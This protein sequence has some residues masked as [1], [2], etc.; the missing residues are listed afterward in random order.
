M[1]PRNAYSVFSQPPTQPAPNQPRRPQPFSPSSPKGPPKGS[2]MKSPS[3]GANRYTP[4]TNHNT[5]S[6]FNRDDPQGRPAAE[7]AF[8]TWNQMKPG[9]S[10]GQ[11]F[12][13]AGADN[14]RGRPA[15]SN[16]FTSK[17]GEDGYRDT[18]KAKP[19]WDNYAERKVPPPGMTRSNTTR[20]PRRNGFDPGTPGGDE[21]AA[22]NTSAYF[23]TSRGDRPHVANPQ[24]YPPPPPGPPPGHQSNVRKPEPLKP[25]PIR[26][27]KS[28]DPLRTFKS[29]QSEDPHSSRLSTPY[30]TS[31]GEKTFFSS[32]GLYRTA[33]TGSNLHAGGQDLNS[34]K[35]ESRSPTAAE[36]H[37]SASPRMRS[38][39]PH[40]SS[41]SSSTSSDEK[42]D[43]MRTRV[44]LKPRGYG[45][46]RNNDGSRSHDERPPQP[47]VTIED[48]DGTTTEFGMPKQRS[49]WSS[50]QSHGAQSQARQF[51]ADQAGPRRTST[52]DIPEGVQPRTKRDSDR[53]PHSPLHT[54]APWNN[55]DVSEPLEK[56][57][58]WQERFG[59]Q[60]D[61]TNRR[62]FD[63][64][65]VGGPKDTRP[66][67]DPSF[68]SRLPSA[69]INCNTPYWAI[70]SSVMPRKQPE[71]ACTEESRNSDKVTYFTPIRT[72][73]GNIYSFTL[74]NES[75]ESSSS[76][77]SQAAEKTTPFSRAEWEKTFSGDANDYL[78]PQNNGSMSGG[79]SSP[80]KGRPAT[81]HVPPKTASKEA[82][83]TKPPNQPPP[84]GPV[85]AP[86]PS[87]AKFSQ[88]Q[89]GEHFKEPSWAYPQ[90]PLSPRAGNSK[91]SKTP[92]KMSTTGKRPVPPSRPVNTPGKV[93]GTGKPG[94]QATVTTVI[95][96]D[97]SS[98]TSSSAMD[99][100]PKHTPPGSSQLGSNHDPIANIIRSAVPGSRSGSKAPSKKSSQSDF[101]SDLNLDDLKHAV[102]FGPNNSGLGDLGDL[103]ATLPFESAPSS[104]GPGGSTTPKDLALPQPPK[105]PH[106]PSTHKLTKESFEY[107]MVWVRK[108]LAEWYIFN[109]TMLAHFN[110]RQS[111]NEVE[112]PHN[113]LESKGE[114]GYLKYMAGV[115]QDFRVR[116]HW[117]V[118]WEK[119]KAAM[120]T[121]GD[122]RRVAARSKF[123]T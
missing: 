112:L 72:N 74:P 81:A 25:D 75:S 105:A 23:N 83:S 123:M 26:G 89:W 29:L 85:P 117:N 15:R 82:V 12:A 27:F 110:A 96:S 113:W 50:E 98:S 41:P 40:Y 90:T 46:A 11:G 22:R 21:P 44:K 18:A 79:R 116:E 62:H 114:E 99:I 34:A 103:H 100:D 66:M 31:G 24:A 10:Q 17:H 5:W 20:A 118:S 37:R 36:R 104:T 52:S 68:S 43:D 76:T 88:E 9:Q 2:S 60:K 102:P 121:L 16:T 70:P 71:A 55:E 8:R 53:M 47:S 3:S 78:A 101:D 6:K 107:Y 33:S 84:T 106:P 86:Q 58:S 87:P 32:D 92:R 4:Y 93:N 65:N 109:K 120:E 28:P 94:L 97:D 39:N 73:Q 35:S 115:Q 67:Y 63:R 54:E 61:G 95:D 48:E 91:W 49:T 108:Y 14:I 77:K 38:P 69:F 122:V 57:P 7:N 56:S 51:A 30:A 45:T 13:P 64:P 80:P 111:K 42:D 59:Y 19:A 119:H 1:P